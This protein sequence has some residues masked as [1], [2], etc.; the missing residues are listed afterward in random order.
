MHHVWCERLEAGA[1]LRPRR[2]EGL[3]PGHHAAAVGAETRRGGDDR[4]T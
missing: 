4:A 2:L 3:D 1:H